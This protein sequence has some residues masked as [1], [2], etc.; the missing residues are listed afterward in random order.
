[1]IA[2]LRV[3]LVLA[4]GVLGCV[5][6]PLGV[7]AGDEPADAGA[8]TRAT[9]G[10]SSADAS[11]ESSGGLDTDEESSDSGDSGET[12]DGGDTDGEPEVDP[13]EIES[14]WSS[15]EGDF[16][17]LALT[18]DGELVLAGADLARVDAAGSLLWQTPIEEG[19]S[20]LLV[21]DSGLIF[22]A[23]PVEA[24]DGS[25]LLAYDAQG[26]LLWT[27]PGYPSLQDL[28]PT[29]DGM[30]GA[31]N[32]CVPSCESQYVQFDD[33]GQ[34]ITITPGPV[35]WVNELE[36]VG[37]RL[38]IIGTTLP[39][40]LMF[41]LNWWGRVAELDHDFDELWFA[42]RADA[43]FMSL[44]VDADL[45]VVGG[46]LV[47]LDEVQDEF[48]LGPPIILGSSLSG[49]AK[50]EWPEGPGLYARGHVAD[51][52]MRDDGSI[53]A[54]LNA[55]ELDP[56]DSLQRTYVQ[57][58]GADGALIQRCRLDPPEDITWA[59]SEF[60]LDDEGAPIV[61]MNPSEAG[62]QVVRVF[63]N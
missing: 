13:C 57:R 27:D 34:L 1:M 30:L 25:K 39:E 7:E 43:S 4:L 37:P 33:Q 35:A 10:E 59:G 44:A 40:P 3:A 38:W 62:A 52:A 47:E 8:T 28:E 46:Y 49:E 5:R 45:V 9:A 17:D 53:V 19:T 12:T 48:A 32:V 6:G 42:E 63:L 2:E 54:L 41:P 23:S 50:F 58:H 14:L 29:I 61:L 21:E 51:L 11:S 22:V 36:A 55:N 20:A 56:P 31:G 15:D 26:Q 18:A 24:T 16:S 60:V